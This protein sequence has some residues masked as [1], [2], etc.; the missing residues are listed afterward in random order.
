MIF[1]AIIGSLV[2]IFLAKKFLFRQP[3]KKTINEAKKVEDT[4][5]AKEEPK[6]SFLTEIEEDTVCVVYGSQ[7]GTAK[8]FAEQL[9]KSAEEQGIKTVLFCASKF[10]PDEL[11]NS[12]SAF[13]FVL[14]TYTDGKPTQTTEAFYNWLSDTSTDF[15]VPRSLYSGSDLHSIPPIIQFFSLDSCVI[16]LLWKR[17][18]LFWPNN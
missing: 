9:V 12:Y 5:V 11:L 8:G 16:S 13:V 15:R 10:D 14:S 6:E 1:W 17:F 7:K 3:E 18:R 4:P 2:V